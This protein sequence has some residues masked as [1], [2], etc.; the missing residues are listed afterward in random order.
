MG[1][2]S[3]SVLDFGI[4]DRL[5]ILVD[6]TPAER[7][8]IEGLEGPV[9]NIPRQMPIRSERSPM[10]PLFALRTGVAISYML[11]SDGSRQILRIH[12]PG[13]LLG[14]PSMPFAT[15]QDTLLALTDVRVAPIDK[16]AIGALFEAHPRVAALFFMVA[17]MERAAA[18]DRLTSIGRTLAAARVGAL[19][20]DMLHRRRMVDPAVG[21]AFSLHLTQE[22]I[23]DATGLTSVHVN[24]MMRVLQ[25]RGLVERRNGDVVILDEVALARLAQHRKRYGGIDLS[26]LPSAR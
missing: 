21:S 7:A 10:Q 4:A 11:L 17:Q 9:R 6:L 24:R 20:L 22:V 15:V 1:G 5:Q 25:D 16:T 14:A 2:L 19:L 18:F 23:A 3:I 13:D 26:W 8:A 12:Q